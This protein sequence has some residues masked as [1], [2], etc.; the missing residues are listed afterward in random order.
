MTLRYKTFIKYFI[1]YFLIFSILFL[2]S[3]FII[4]TQL[5]NQYFEIICE[6]NQDKLIS[7]TTQLEDDTIYLSQIHK[8]LRANENILKY[9]YSSDRIYAYPVSQT[10]IQANAYSR[11]IDHIVLQTDSNNRIIAT[12][13]T[14]LMQNNVFH[15]YRDD[16]AYI[17]FD[18]SQ[19]SESNQNQLISIGNNDFRKIIYYPSDNLRTPYKLFYL[20]DTDV[21]TQ[22]LKN[23]SSET[24]EAF[25]LFDQYG[26]IAASI[27]E[28]ALLPCMEN[29]PK[30]NGIFR[31]DDT[32]TICVQKS[33]N[34]TF[35]ILALLSNEQL[36][37]QISIAFSKS[38]LLLSL[39]GILGFVLLLFAMQI[40]YR[41][42]HKITKLVSKDFT[43]QE[44]YI[45]QLNNAFCSSNND[46]QKLQTK[47]KDYRLFMQKS[48]LDSII[49]I[50]ESTNIS[51]NINIDSFFDSS[52]E[53]NIFIVYAEFKKN[54]INPN[55]VEL[56]LALFK[57]ERSICTILSQKGNS[58]AL[59][60]NDIGLPAYKPE[61]LKQHFHLFHE[62][63]G[64]M[65]SFS[66]YSP[67]PLDIPTLFE[68][69]MNACTLWK[70]T[71]PVSY[72][73]DM[74]HEL[75]EALSYPHE[76]IEALGEALESYDVQKVRSLIT[77]LLKILDHLDLSI[78]KA[79]DFFTRCLLIDILASIAEALNQDYIPFEDYSDVY[80]DMLYLCRSTPYNQN[81]LVISQGIE[82]LLTLYEKR[83]L[84]Q[85]VTPKK[86]QKC[87]EDSFRNPDF[88]I[89][90]LADTFHTSVP[91]MS[92]MVTELLKDNFS[93]IL[94]NIRFEET[95]RLLHNPE[96]TIDMIGVSIG[97]PNTR[98]F[99]R[100]FKQETG[101]SP[102]EYRD[103][104]CNSIKNKI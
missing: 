81:Q 34:N 103:A 26:Q 77:E 28:E 93:N 55:D 38:Y 30:E 33:A 66:N 20:L 75:P 96:L 56:L 59:L 71:H 6:Q 98:S 44:D 9:I 67:S 22:S 95:K 24:M 11:L 18:P 48:L 84:H 89:A 100:K 92:K 76:Q 42:L 14:I 40:T 60:I 37:Q 63:T 101:F 32:N 70:D 41:P 4:R 36:S 94:W 39:L 50:D 78:T 19:Y 16:T 97:Y 87:F 7:F 17:V 31:L 99:R 49:S 10:L 102:S 53:K 74:T 12:G 104:N 61:I 35:T 8:S 15:L 52:L 23:I 3:F 13:Q 69:V 29:I 90:M 54:P 5:T 46:I 65:I 57:E 62:Q 2:G 91:V 79:P 73:P 83:N 82:K 45:E 1:S 47:L 64:A 86:L 58:I 43:P 51:Y 25:I 27:N 72:Y 21:I 88:S 85:I 80:Y 68:N